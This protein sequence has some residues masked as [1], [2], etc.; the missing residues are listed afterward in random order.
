MKNSKFI[1]FICS[2]NVW[3]PESEDLSKANNKTQKWK[4]EESHEKP[5]EKF[6]KLKEAKCFSVFPQF[7]IFKN[8]RMIKKLLM[9]EASSQNESNI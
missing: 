8:P 9:K 2:C 6:E 3:I 4:T 7:F 5:K 1:P